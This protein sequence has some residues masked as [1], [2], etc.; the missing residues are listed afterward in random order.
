M[1]H[2]EFL[3]FGLLVAV[4]G[5]V[6]LAGFLKV[7]Y[8][9]MLVIGGLALGFVPGVPDVELSPET[10]L[11]LF[12]PPLLYS[13]A[14]FASLRDLRADVRSISLLA[15]GLVVATAAAV[16]MPRTR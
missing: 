12:L 1:E 15:I 2:T 6:L 16:A 3:L 13:A 8:P 4:S 5:L 11:L 9:V 7:P 10:V 14:F